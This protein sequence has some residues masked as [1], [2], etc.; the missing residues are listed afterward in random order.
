M[1]QIVRS[2]SIVFIVSAFIGGCFYFLNV[3]FWPVF[4][5]SVVSQFIFFEIFRKWNSSKL[6]VEMETILNERMKE[7]D[8]IGI[9][10]TCPVET[11]NVKTFVPINMNMENEYQCEGCKSQVKVMIGTKTFLKTTPIDGDPFKNHN[12]VTNQDY[13]Q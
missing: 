13:E 4:G 9:D 12:F 7:F 6:Q 2:L 10:A 11:C 1:F 5:L 8:K 3:S